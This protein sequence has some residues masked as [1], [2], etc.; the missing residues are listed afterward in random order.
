MKS[1][2]KKKAKNV[3]LMS[4]IAKGGFNKYSL[5]AIAFLVW[6]SFFDRNNLF[7]QHKLTEKLEKLRNEKSEYERLLVEAKEEKK[8]LEHNKERYAREK[9]FAKKDNEE[10]YIIDR[11]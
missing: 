1:S 6:I 5:S 4:I 11:K 10:V 3:S 8:N 7:V 2:K 9:Y